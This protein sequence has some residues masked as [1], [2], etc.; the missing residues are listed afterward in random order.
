MTRINVYS[1]RPD[2]DEDPYFEPQFLGWFDVDKVVEDIREDTYW[3][4]NNHRGVMSKL[5]CGHERLY[6]TN[7]GRWVRYYNARSEFN[8]PEF[9]E[10]LTDEQAR[11]WLLRN[12]DDESNAAAAR[13]F[14][15]TPEEQGP[16]R[17]DLGPPVLIR[18][19]E[20]ILPVDDWAEQEG[21]SRAEAVR[22][23]VA[24]ALDQVRQPAAS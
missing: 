20:L 2:G 14:G 19:G 9:Y 22:R 16:G 6:R 12:N 5:Q 23:L 18:L 3:D 24:L 7:K 1:R 10:Y 13:Y 21:I 17:P 15:E 8:G 4:G 11:D